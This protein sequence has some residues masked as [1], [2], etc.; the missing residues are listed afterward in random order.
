MLLSEGKHRG[1]RS[2]EEGGVGKLGRVEGGVIICVSEAL[3]ERRIREGE[4]ERGER[5]SDGG[6][7]RGEG[8]EREIMDSRHS[9]GFPNIGWSSLEMLSSLFHTLEAK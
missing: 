3:N 9:N 6:R 5:E 2:R 4:N 8:R 1:H 7:R